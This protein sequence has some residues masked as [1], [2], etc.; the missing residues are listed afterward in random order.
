MKKF[1]FFLLLG[2]MFSA[3]ISAQAEIDSIVVYDWD[4][5]RLGEDGTLYLGVGE[6]STLQFAIYPSDINLDTVSIVV[7]ADLPCE[8]STPDDSP[9]TIDGRNITGTKAGRCA[10]YVCADEQSTVMVPLV[11]SYVASGS[12][13]PD[14][15]PGGQVYYSLNSKGT[16]QFWA[17]ELDKNKPVP[18]DSIYEIPSYDSAGAAPWYLMRESIKEIILDNLDNIGSY[19]FN[20]L[21][22]IR[23]VKFPSDIQYLGDFV[24][25]GC[26]NLKTLEVARWGGYAEPGITYT[27]GTALIIS[28][29]NPDDPTRPELVLVDSEDEGALDYYRSADSEWGLCGRVIAAGG[30]LDGE[31]APQYTLTPSETTGGLQLVLDHNGSSEE[32]AVLPD[33]K[34]ADPPYPWEEL[35]DLVE[36]LQIHDRVRYIGQGVFSTLTNLQTIQFDQRTAPVDSIHLMAF[37][38]EITPWKFALGDPQ[39]GPIL[40]PKITGVENASEALQ[41]WTHFAQNT[42]LY[43]PDST[44]I[45]NNKEVRSINLYRADPVWGQVFNRLTDRTVDTVTHTDDVILKWLPLENATCYR[46]IIHKPGCDE[47]LDTLDIPATGVQGL[48]DWSQIPSNDSPAGAPHRIIRIKK[49]DEHGGM[50]LTISLQ[51]GSGIAH[52]IDVSVAVSGMEKD[53]EYAFSREVFKIN[54]A[55]GVLAKAGKFKLEAPTYTVTF[56]DKDGNTLKTEVIKEGNAAT[57]PSAPSVTGYHF[58]GWDKAFDNVTS[59]LTVKAQYAINVYTVTFTDKDGNTLKTESVEHGKGATAPSAPSVTGY[60]FTSWDKAF[61]NV[62]S[63]LTVM[64]Q[65][66]INVYTVTFVDKDGNTLKTENVEYGNAAT[67][68]SAPSVTGYH[69]TGWDKAFDNVTSDLTVK[70][71]YAINVYTVTFTDKDGNTLKTE[72]VEHGNAAT[73]PSAPSVTGYHFTGWDKAFDNVTSDLTVKAQY[74]INVYTVTFTDK[75][76]NTLKTE[77]VEHGNAATAP[78]APSVTGYHFTGWD[79]AFYNVTSDLTVKAQYAIN[80]YTV[81]FTDKDGNTLKTESVE[82]GKGATAPSAPSVTGYH[83]TGW[84]KDFDNVTSDLTVKAQY[85]INVYTVTFVGFDGTA[86]KTENVEYGN[87]ATAPDA[88]EVEGY[89]F[90]GWDKGF[91]YITSDLTVTAQYLINLYSVTFIGFDGRILWS[92]QVEH[93][94]A[95]T[96][97]D[98]PEIEGYAFIGWDTDF[99]NVTS[100]L[101]V[102][103]IYEKL[104]DYTPTNLSALVETLDNDTRITLS[105]DKVDGAASYELL[106]L[107]GDEELYAGNTFGLNTISLTLS[108]LLQIVSIAPGTYLLDWMVRS[109]DAEGQPLSEW[110]K[111]ETFEI[112]IQDPGQGIGDIPSEGECVHKEM[113]NGLLYIIRNGQTYDSNGKQVH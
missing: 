104:P 110:A 30:S 2:L 105:W 18:S 79:K 4:G 66:A 83:F 52:T 1:Y 24:F 17:G 51:Q 61:D 5:S 99:S 35:G 12:L 57:A 103:A 72:S 34:E 85:A 33:K 82:H 14:G 6:T 55:D 25:S 15:A 22:N 50:T 109:T 93:G 80:V 100:N 62:T 28:E 84:D 91:A 58:T 27:S 113:R 44:F 88:P 36:D 42:V 70:A 97:P 111:G 87:A 9:V 53:Q 39:D 59:D 101:T 41:S 16:L 43:V 95:A 112:T 94:H 54:G 92:E 7:S 78:S 40:P 26:A 56:V 37:S 10:L 81:T 86:L 69:F 89:T 76:G 98:A 60:H 46:L 8:G 21:T 19:A 45:Y 96:A 67:A 77:S 3:N 90:L 71:Q 107:L 29:A 74:A 75:D 32:D 64:A 38:S 20:N 49:E 23:Y 108:D 13:Y 11:V 68:P 63:D 73:A 47:C 102:T 65:Y 31:S 106:L 48:V